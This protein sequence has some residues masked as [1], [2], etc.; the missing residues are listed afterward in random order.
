M[1]Q[2]ILVTGAA[3][4]IGRGIAEL[5][6]KNNYQ[7]I[8]A[9]IDDSQAKELESQGIQFYKV[10][11]SDENSIIQFKK[12][13]ADQEIFALINNAGIADPYNKPL[14]ELE[15]SE[16]ENILRTNLSSMFLMTKHFSE[17]LISNKG[18]IVNISSIRAL[19][20]EANTEAYM[21]AK[22]GVI[23]LTMALADSLKHKLR[24]NCISPGW[25]ET[26]VS[27]PA[28]EEVKDFHLVNRVGNTNDI[29]ELV[30]F[31][32]SDKASFITGQNFVV[33]GGAAQ[34]LAYP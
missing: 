30:L 12:Q 17:N 23:G 24:V 6:L 10:D 21:T 2:V 18:S 31:L 1:V 26:R 15:L 14:N 27:A 9:D 19:R 8:A 25:I 13:I 32:I 16:W 7:V 3:N 28:T 11:V 5:A 22:S 34:R 4:G 33:D 20:S 29:S